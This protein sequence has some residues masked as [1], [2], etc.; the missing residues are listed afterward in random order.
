[1]VRSNLQHKDLFVKVRKGDI[2]RKNLVNPKSQNEGVQVMFWGFFSKHDLG[3]LVPIEGKLNA[4][5]YKTK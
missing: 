1:M 5:E 3:P 2:K 4:L